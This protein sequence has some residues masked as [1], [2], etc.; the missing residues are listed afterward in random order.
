MGLNYWDDTG[1]SGKHAHVDESV[2]V[3]SVNVTGFTYNLG[4][5]DN[6]LI[7]YVLYAFD[8]DDGTVVLLEHNNT[9]YMV[10]DMIDYLDDPIKCEDND[11]RINL[12][13][14]LYDSNNN[15]T[16]S[17]TFPDKNPIP[18]EY[19][20]VLPCTAFHIPAK[21]KV[22]T[23]EQIDLTSKFNWDTYGKRGSFSKVEYQYNAIY[24]V[25]ESFEGKDNI[26]AKLS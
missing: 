7:S 20:V 12:C 23:F 22:K 5:I 16:Q 8:K 17:I 24:S 9:I 10:D 1:C 18:V 3:N 4:S 15:N 14:K 19:N 13:P 6:L 26:S 25:L 11:A 2:E 21:Y